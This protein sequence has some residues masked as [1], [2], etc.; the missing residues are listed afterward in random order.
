MG[1]VSPASPTPPVGMPNAGMAERDR[2]LFAKAQELE[3]TFL[4]EMLRH[5]GLGET[6]SPFSGG[7]GE[8]QFASFLRH[9]QAMAMARSGGIGLA[10][11]LFHAMKRADDA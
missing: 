1:P 10:E 3:A 11:T 7:I 5:A 8:E 6:E 2:A 4:A 9:E